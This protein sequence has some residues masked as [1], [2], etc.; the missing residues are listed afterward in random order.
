MLDPAGA[1][2]PTIYQGSD[3]N[4]YLR[5]GGPGVSTYYT[6]FRVDSMYVGNGRVIAPGEV[7]VTRSSSATL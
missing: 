3:D 1:F 6:S 2:N 4:V 5:F 7:T